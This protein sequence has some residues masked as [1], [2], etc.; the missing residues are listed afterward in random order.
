MRRWF[1]VSFCTVSIQLFPA[2]WNLNANGN[3]NVNGNWT[4]PAIFPNGVDAAAIFGNVIT[5]NRTVTLGIPITI[6]SIS[7][8]DDNNYLITASTLSFQTSSGNA[9]LGVTNLNGNGSH[10]IA[11][12]VSLAN[13]LN[14]T[15]SSNANFTISG[16]I[17]GAGGIIKNGTGI[18]SLLLNNALNSYGGSTTINQGNL[19]Y[20]LAGSIPSTSAVTIGNGVSPAS[21]IIA[22]NMASGNAFDVSINTNGSLAPNNNITTVI[23]SLQ[24]AGSVVLTA[25][26]G[27]TN[28]LDIIGSSNTVFSGSISGGAASASTD[29]AVANRLIKTGTGT[30][31]LTGTSSYLSRTF[32]QNGILDVQSSGA[33]GPSGASSAVYVQAIGTQGSLYID[34]N[35]LNLPKTLFLNGPGYSSGALRNMNGNNTI[36]G[37]VQIGWT[38]GTETP[39]TNVTIQI[40]SGTQ[41]SLSGIISGASNLTIQGGGTLVYS[42]ALANTMSGLT[43]I[44]AGVL[45]LNKPGSVNAIAGNVAINSGSTLLSSAPNQIIDTSTITLAGGTFD[46]GGNIETIGSLIFNAGTL[47]QGIATLGISSAA[48]NALSMND[49]TVIG[50]S[51][52]FTAAG[53]LVYN[54]AINRATISGTLDLSSFAHTFNIA[55]GADSIDM[56]ISGQI[57]GT[58]SIAQSTGTGVL[59]FSGSSANTYSGLTT[60]NAGTLQL[61]KSAGTNAIGGNLTINAGATAVLLAPDQI[62]NSSTVTISGGTFN[63]NNQQDTIGS[64]IYNSGTFTQGTALLTLSGSSGAALTFGNGVTIAGNLAMTGSGDVVYN[65]T[66][67]TATMNGNL[68]LG[69][70]IH[71]FNIANG[72]ATPDLLLSG[73]ISGSGGGVTKIS[74]GTLQFSG[75]SSN[76]YSGLTSV[77]AG[78]LVLGKTAG[79][80]AIAGDVLVNGGTLTLSVADQIANTSLVTLS[81]G[82]FNMGGLAET[83][84]T[85]AYNGGTFTQAGATLTMASSTTALSMRNTTISGALVVSGGGAIVFDATNNGTGVISGNLSLTGGTP[86]FDI[87]NG[88]AATD[89]QVSGVI[90][91]TGAG[92]TKIGAGTLQFSGA[93]ANTYSGLTTVSNGTLSLNKTA[94]INAVGGD[95][96][97]NGGTLTLGAANQIPNT[98]TVT[99]SSGTWD[100]AG[101]SETVATLNFNGGTLSQGIGTLTLGSSATALSMRNT[102]IN[103]NLSITNGGT[104]AFDATNNG[105]ATIAGNVALGAST[106]SFIVADGSAAIDLSISGIISS[107]GAGITVSGPGVLEFSGGSANTY[108]GLTTISAGT[109]SLNKTAGI[110]S[111]PGNITIN[112]GVL[113]LGNENQIANTS[114]VTLSNGAFNLN[115]F[116]ETI[117]TLNFNGG[118]LSQ[119]GATLTLASAATALSMRNTTITGTLA[120]TG[121]GAVVFDA[122]NNGTATISG[123]MDLGGA[124]TSFSIANGTASTDMLISGIISNGGLTKTGLGTLVLSGANNYAGG[125][126]VSAGVLQGDS[127]SLQGA[128]TNNASLVFD[129]DF[130][131]SYT[132]SMSGGGS[133]FKEGSGTLML[134]NAN[135]AGSVFLNE[136]TLIVNGALG[137]GGTMTIV[138]GATLKGNGTITKNTTINGTLSP[139]NSIGT[140]NFVGNQTFASTSELI[141]ELNP[142]TSD[143]VNITGNLTIELGASLTI[144]PESGTYTAPTTYTIIQTSTGVTGKFSTVTNS[145]PLFDMSV[146]YTDFNVLLQLNGFVPFSNLVTNKNAKKVAHCLDTLSASSGSDLALI[147]NTLLTLSTPAEIEEALFQ[148]QPSKFTSLALAQENDTLYVSNT[149]LNRLDEI[150]HSCLELY[151]KSRIWASVLGGDTFQQEKSGEPGYHAISPGLALGVEGSFG[152][153]GYF[154][155][156]LAYTYSQ[157]QWKQAE[158]SSAKIQAIYAGFYGKWLRESGYLEGALFGS[159]DLYNTERTIEFSNISRQAKGFHA[160]WEGS[161]HL[162]G[163]WVF[164]DKSNTML[165]PFVRFDYLFLHENEFA[166]MGAGSLNLFIQSKNSD[167]LSS[168]G[169]LDL[170]YCFAVGERTFSPFVQVSAIRESRFFGQKEKACFGGSCDCGTCCAMTVTGLYPSRTLVGTYL[171]LNAALLQSDFSFFYRGKYGMKFL[172]HSLYFQFGA[173]F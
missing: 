152:L 4:T 101:L 17:S 164:Y 138:P 148:M 172:D 168:E 50:G 102:T 161:C 47:T 28:H 11:S 78:T 99:L 76:T 122:T 135:T 118:S 68:D 70:Q 30:L 100:L 1:I 96:L 3:W 159:Y 140:L 124:V 40:D 8:D 155:G 48:A 85:F 37:G 132:S 111:I 54:G 64:L 98:S 80:I 163:G 16:A 72:T 154:G 61:N 55:N 95:V 74:A 75:G 27:N 123:P 32:V 23:K 137:G 65:G 46:L 15:L 44:S 125:T 29:P 147:K 38:G 34:G 167:L 57:I 45:Q 5:A 59:Q 25:G 133:L 93:S 89:M 94:N 134:T 112:G 71:S 90:S 153:E 33:L 58:G 51:V 91:S 126:I 63:M 84:G 146:I 52:A 97:I 60:I 156:C 171:G 43:T 67:A 35:G 110:N 108:T 56:L 142:S 157:L 87:A 6:G 169:G 92:I 42:G 13:T 53:G 66:T 141:N 113:S 49:N 10:S 128:I 166:E 114:T 21:L 9:S 18:G 162:K 149:V 105:T 69:T 104:I 22:A 19:T 127:I 2:T 144:L 39:A 88:I 31:T 7:F 121:G 109:L 24:G 77:T 79:F 145:A 103:G 20:N 41:L 117:A 129:Q 36:T 170:S 173:K 151:S 119:S 86:N 73:V 12:A 160:G 136:G 165:M 120:F 139:G 143:L 26:T 106:S 14:M 81:S 158:D 150:T 83:I 107:T 62:S 116:L 115:N 130:S 82:T 131:G